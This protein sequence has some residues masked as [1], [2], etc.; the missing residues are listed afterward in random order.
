M[1]NLLWLLLNVII[2]STTSIHHEAFLDI[3]MC[4]C[5]Y[6]K[7]GSPGPRME[8]QSTTNVPLRAL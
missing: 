4:V 6:Y 7:S 2:I 8:P 1:A 3:Y 5:V